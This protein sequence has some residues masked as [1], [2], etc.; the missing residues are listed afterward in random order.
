V[1]GNVWR[2]EGPQECRIPRSGVSAA[3]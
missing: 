3:S 2:A 1:N